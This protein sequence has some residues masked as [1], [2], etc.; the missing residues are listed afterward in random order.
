MTPVAA[1]GQ[2]GRRV[3]PLLLTSIIASLAV[4]L[5]LVFLVVPGLVLAFLFAFA[6]PVVMLE[7]KGGVA[8]LKRSIALVLANL[9]PTFI[10]LLVLVPPT[11]VAS[12]IGWLIIPNSWV[13]AH[14]LAQGLL[15][16]IV[17]PLPIIGLV[18]LY[19]GARE[20]TA[21]PMLVQPLAAQPS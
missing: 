1:W 16:V 7:N 15:S 12:V 17:F 2:V 19:R 20:P 18:L 11:L 13:F 5:G 4:M 9:V 8:A 10:V 14:A 6:A 3:A 21:P